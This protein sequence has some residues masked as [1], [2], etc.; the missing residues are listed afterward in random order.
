MI[1][2][3]V[4]FVKLYLVAKEILLRHV[5]TRRVSKVRL[6]LSYPCVCSVVMR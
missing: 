6:P 2:C 3:N 5:A 4:S 1:Y